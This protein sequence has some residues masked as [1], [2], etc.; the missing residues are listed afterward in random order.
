M[1]GH[2]NF[3]KVTSTLKSQKKVKKC[4]PNVLNATQPTKIIKAFSGTRKLN[5]EMKYLN[6]KIAHIPLLGKIIFADTY[7]SHTLNQEKENMRM[8]THKSNIA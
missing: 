7:L 5:M 8:I 2:L 6:V 3:K 1:V 4:L